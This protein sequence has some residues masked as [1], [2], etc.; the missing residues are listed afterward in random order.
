MKK[1]KNYKKVILKTSILIA[2]I[3][4]LVISLNSSF[5]AII[6]VNPANV[7]GIRQGLN[8]AIDNQNTI[9]LA[10]GTYRGT[11]NTNLTITK[12]V[13]IQGNGPAANVI[14]DAQGLRRIFN[15]SNNVNVMFINITFRNGRDS[16]GGAIYNNYTRTTMTFINCT[17][18]NNTAT[19]GT[20]AGAIYNAGGNLNVSGSNFTNN[21][22]SVAAGILNNAVANLSVSGSIFTNN[23]ATVGSGA[24]IWYMGINL[25]VIDSIFI[26]NSANVGGAIAIHGSNN[27]GVSGSIFINNTVNTD[28]GA[29]YSNV[30]GANLS[31]GDSNFINNTANRD[32]GAIYNGGFNMNVTGSNF[33]NNSAVYGGAIYNNVYGVNM[34]VTD[35]NFT[36][37]TANNRSGAIYNNGANSSVSGSTFIN[38]TANTGGAIFNIGVN[39]SVSGSNFINNTALTYGGAIYSNGVNLSVSGS[40]F[41][42]NTANNRGGAIYNTGVNLSVSGSNFTN[43]TA[44][45]SGGALINSGDNMGVSGSTFINNTATT[46]NGGA[47]VND[48]GDN[49]RVSGSNFINN[50]AVVASGGAISISASGNSVINSTISGSTF[51]NNTANTGGAISNG[52]NCFNMNVSG[53]NFINNSAVYGGG[54]STRSDN[55]VIM[56]SNF[57]GNSH[58]VGLATT[59]FTLSSNRIFNNTVGIQF[60]LTNLN[61]TIVGLNNTNNI[62]D[63]LYAVDISGSNS[64]YTVIA[65]FGYNNNGGFIFANGANG[66]RLTGNF[67]GYNR[68]DDSG[69]AVMFN[70]T[71]SNNWLYNSTIRGNDFGIIFN[72]TNNT[73]NGSTILNNLKGGIIVYNVTGNSI[74]YNRIYDNNGTGFDMVNFGND[75]NADLNWWGKNNITG[76]VSGINTSNHYI[77]NITNISSLDNVNIGDSASFYLLV[78]NTT[79][80]NIGVENLPYFVINGTFNGAPYNSSRDDLFIYNF[81]ILS[82]GIQT[83]TASLDEQDVNMTFFEAMNST[84]STIVVIPNPAQIGE[85]VTIS[86]HLDN[87]TGIGSVNVTVD[88]TI[89]LNVP[90]NSTTGG[91]SL[92]YTTNRTGNLTVVVSFVGNE[93]YTSFTN[94]TNFIVA[95]NG[96]NSTIV[97]IPNPAQIGENVTISGYLANFTGI[98]SVDVIVDGTL[99]NVFVDGF[100]YWELN[101][102]TN[103]TGTFN[104]VVNF[105]GNENYTSF[106]NTTSFNVRKLAVNSTVNIPEIA[107]MGK[108]ITIDGVLVDEN[109]N[110]VANAPITVTVDGKVYPLITDSNGRWS[111]TYK[112]THTGNVTIMVEYA[113]NDKYFSYTNTTTFNVVKGEAIVDVNVV[114]NSDG[115]VDVIVTVTDVDDDPIPDYEVNVDLDG[116]HI[117]NIV[118]GDDGIGKIHISST[119]LND[120]RHVIIVTSNDVNYSFNPVSVE[121]E[122][123]NNKNDTNNTNKTSDNPVAN[124]TMKNTGMPVITILLVVLTI[125]GIAIRRKQD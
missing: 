104:T 35:S 2:T 18:I 56:D 87:H 37:N 50:T 62:T 46:G 98:A 36:N 71:S 29:I 44:F 61:Y 118:T 30:A 114:K 84:N 99:F 66:N 27:V 110:P 122:I 88:G 12:N 38:N 124:A 123:Q 54:V 102:T 117:V 72:G 69:V 113:G 59:N 24:G 28:G 23:R 68:S 81:T 90:V 39:L 8:S 107:K 75:T 103:Y 22:A 52:N 89:F 11:N 49:M 5:A 43:N 45:I 125:F 19:S 9:N 86:G 93:N 119:K 80:D 40:N 3:L 20:G 17:F 4:L 91:W 26:N 112:P 41:T 10:T 100:G 79:F 120:G 77:L 51:I 74:N 109:G 16:I 70:D 78:L 63:N 31:I 47:V 58:A 96:T 34:S 73:L 83:V 97:V 64:N 14:I 6:N 48:N 108:T 105:A 53:S 57:T 116:K 15:M 67:T 121:F 92:N 111:L 115:S 85:N 76:I 82:E 1:I 65:S 42:N 21:T 94:S 7:G 25:S 60:I 106:T 32:G 13:T 55:S 95:K 33:I 101:Y